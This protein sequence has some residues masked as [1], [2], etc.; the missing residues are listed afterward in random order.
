MLRDY[1]LVPTKDVV[2][3]YTIDDFIEPLALHDLE[4][5]HSSLRRHATTI[6]A[7]KKDKEKAEERP[8]DTRQ[9]VVYDLWGLPLCRW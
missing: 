7:Q 8:D 1:H 2:E 4:D 9:D 6:K 5:V 3:T